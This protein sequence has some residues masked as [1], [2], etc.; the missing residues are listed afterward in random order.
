MPPELGNTHTYVLGARTDISN[1]S[2]ASLF[3]L[4]SL[5]LH[6]ALM[7]SLCD[8]PDHLQNDQCTHGKFWIENKTMLSW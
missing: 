8:M 6:L 4:N 1:S 2:L 5:I 7:S 3:F